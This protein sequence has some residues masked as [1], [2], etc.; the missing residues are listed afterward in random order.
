[1]PPKG[2]GKID[3]KQLRKIA[4]STPAQ[5]SLSPAYYDI[6]VFSQAPF[7]GAGAGLLDISTAG[8]RQRAVPGV[9]GDLHV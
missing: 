7:T 4:V 6:H 9:G 3:I 1:M 5:G 8:G 2:P